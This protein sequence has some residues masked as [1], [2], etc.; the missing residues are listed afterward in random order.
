MIPLPMTGAASPTGAASLG[1][2]LGRIADR[3]SDA[4]GKPRRRPSPPLDVLIETVLSQNT[5][6]VNSGRAFRALKRAYP[7]WR[8]AAGARPGALE[9]VIRSGGLARLKSRRILKLL[10]EVERR[11]GRLS[12]TRLRRLDAAA[13]AQRLLGLAGVGPKTRACVLLFGCGKHAFPV[14]THVH[15]LALRLR[16]VSPRTTAAAA[17]ALLEPAVPRGRALE[18]HLN[19]IRLGREV[20]RARAPRCPECPLRASCPSRG[21]A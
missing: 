7:S 6:D 13:A 20:C 21:R 18:L 3:L 8:A 10:A 4:Y 2:R 16:L 15:R 19:L 12:L 14:D 9:R 17:Q 11:E 1:A 5:S